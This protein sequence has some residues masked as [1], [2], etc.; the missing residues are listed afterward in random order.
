MSGATPPL[1]QYAYM[2]WCSAKAQGQLYL[3]HHVDGDSRRN[4][5]LQRLTVIFSF[6]YHK[7]DV[8]LI[9]TDL[10]AGLLAVLINVAVTIK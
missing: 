4:R 3:Y 1:P 8:A 2:A 9:Y 5:S 10:C 6:Y 7:S